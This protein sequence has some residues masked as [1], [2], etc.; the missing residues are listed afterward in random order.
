MKQGLTPNR[1]P[2]RILAILQAN[3]PCTMTHEQI[4]Y[5]LEERFGTTPPPATIRKAM[6][7]LVANGYATSR[8]EEWL[9][10]DT[11]GH[12]PEAGVLFGRTS[13]YVKKRR[14]R[15]GVA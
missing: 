4:R 12:G 6:I 14:I 10:Y 9:D 13:W 8:V 5:E 11:G 2:D 7:R 3:E 1:T 15:L